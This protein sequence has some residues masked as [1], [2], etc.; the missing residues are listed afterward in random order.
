MSYNFE[1]HYAQASQDQ[2]HLDQLNG[3][4]FSAHLENVNAL[5]RLQP[6]SIFISTDLMQRLTELEMSIDVLAERLGPITKILDTQGPMVSLSVK[7]IVLSDS[8]IRA[9]L[10]ALENKIIEITNKISSMTNNLETL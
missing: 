2:S 9:K 10:C 5:S 7:Q 6:L 1:P 3:V 8:D 4:G